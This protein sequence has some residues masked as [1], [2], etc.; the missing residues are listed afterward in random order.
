MKTSEGYIRFF[1]VLLLLAV[2]AAN[3]PVHA[4]D[5][6]EPIDVI[7]VLD[8]SL[9]MEDKFTAVR[10]YVNNSIIDQ[11]LIPGDLFILITFY[12]KTEVPVARRIASDN[13]KREIKQIVSRLR[14]DGSYT[15]IGNALDVLSR[16]LAELSDPSRRKHLL[17]LTDGK[18]EA[19]RGSRY[20]SPDGSFNHDFLANT[21]IIQKQGWKIHVLGIGTEQEAQKLAVELSGTFSTITDTLTSD[22]LTEQTKG[23]LGRV[24]LQGTPTLQPISADGRSVLTL[25]LASSQYPE[26][27]HIGA[28]RLQLD[29]ADRRWEN[30][31]GNQLHED[32]FRITLPP[33]GTTRVDIPIRLEDPPAAGAYQGS[34]Q[35]LFTA[36]ESFLP[37]V[38]EV[39][40]R[41]Q[42]P[43]EWAFSGRYIPW[44]LAALAVLLGLL[45]LLLVLL[46]RRGRF[47]R[48]RFR[49][50]V[51]GQPAKPGTGVYALKEGRGLFVNETGDSIVLV[52]SRNPESVARVFVTM[53]A[54][55]MNVLRQ[56]RFPK[57]RDMPRDIR[58]ASF[59]IRA[60]SGR[61]LSV[62][63]ERLERHG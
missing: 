42:S 8:K 20:Y 50:H 3:Q 58:G 60:E 37:S 25:E 10:D 52:E 22:L 34:L 35:F 11:M 53:G 63:F 62:K 32:S 7:L 33:E 24:E 59:R 5:R 48:I 44:T 39:R 49:I 41:V 57:L 54:L 43:L 51:E 30:I 29:L 6:T 2:V 1:S 26:E 47:P 14:A 56:E 55:R 21:K 28:Q 16:K 19:P 9:S 38:T 13:D 27:V 36:G 31:L 18:Q 12:G 45:V 46:V 15:D 61:D 23:L 17:L 4:D 40:F